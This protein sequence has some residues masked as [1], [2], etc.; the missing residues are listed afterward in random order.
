MLDLMAQPSVTPA[1]LLFQQCVAESSIE[2]NTLNFIK[3]EISGYL[4]NKVKPR[5]LRKN[6]WKK[7]LASIKSS[8]RQKNSIIT[9][10]FYNNL[11]VVLQD[12]LS[13]KKVKWKNYSDVKVAMLTPSNEGDKLELIHVM[14]GGSIP[15]HTHEGKENF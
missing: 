14:P 2:G 6:V 7:T 3:N 10:P 8:N 5:A 15:Q 4:L 11:P 12:Y 13:N 1:K 9:D